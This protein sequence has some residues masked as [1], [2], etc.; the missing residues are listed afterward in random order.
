MCVKGRKIFWKFKSTTIQPMSYASLPPH[1]LPLSFFSIWVLSPFFCLP[2]ACVLHHLWLRDL[3]DW[4]Y[5]PFLPAL[6]L[7]TLL[8]YPLT[9]C[10]PW[11]YAWYFYT[12]FPSSR[13]W[14]DLAK[15]ASPQAQKSW[16]P[17]MTL[18]LFLPSQLC[19]FL[20]LFL[21]FLSHLSFPSIIVVGPHRSLL[22]PGPI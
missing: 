10:L 20:A 21:P 19:A 15:L 11:C 4:C 6:V 17:V 22:S 5:R 16:M 13:V 14:L 7:W 9:S 8:V 18:I 12:Y 1:S 3:L 2:R